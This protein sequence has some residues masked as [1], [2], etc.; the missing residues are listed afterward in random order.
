MKEE[1]DV[2]HLVLQSAL[3]EI[4]S[5][6]EDGS[7][8]SDPCVICLE[9]VSE[10][11]LA[12]PC[13]HNSFDFLCLVSWLQERPAC[14]LCKAQIEA[15]EYTSQGGTGTKTYHVPKAATRSPHPPTISDRTPH[16]EDVSINRRPRRPQTVQP[17]SPLSPDAALLRR[18]QIYEKGLY[19]LHVGSNRLSRFRELSPQTFA[20][21]CELVSRARK[22]IRRELRVF[23]FLGVDGMSSQDVPRRVNNAEFLLEYIIAIL[24][25]V[26]IKS[27]GGQAEEMLQEFLG[28]DNARLFLHEL[29]AWLRSPYTEL[30][31]WDRWVQYDET[32]RDQSMRRR[33][34]VPARSADLV[35]HPTSS[36]RPSFPFHRNG[37]QSS[38]RNPPRRYVD[39]YEPYSARFR[40]ARRF[41]R[42]DPG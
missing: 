24:K 7:G 39:H 21:D 4:R 9:A 33:Q 28:R 5:G 34:E 11:A 31:D 3:K 10:P 35:E 26:D 8:V 40:R 36:N 13:R 20:R 14:P 42:M 37:L 1:G 17:R 2:E 25:T 6:I 19:S 18:R 41:E 15:V 30:Q 27:S 32:T 22:W 29:R 23:E 38:K 16:R 12:T